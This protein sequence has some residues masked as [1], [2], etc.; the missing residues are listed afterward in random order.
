MCGEACA[1]AHTS[2]NACPVPHAPLLTNDP[3]PTPPLAGHAAAQQLRAH[4]QHGGPV[5]PPH[6]RRPPGRRLLLRHKVRCACHHRGAA[7]GGTRGQGAAQGVGHLAGWVCRV[8]SMP[9][10][11]CAAVCLAS[12]CGTTC[13]TCGCH[14]HCRSHA[15]LLSMWLL[16]ASC[17]C[18]QLPALHCTPFRCP[19]SGV[20][21]PA[22]IV[23]CCTQLPSFSLPPH[24]LPHTASVLLLPAGIVET[25]FF[26]VRAFGDP[27]AAK[28]AT[29]QFK[30][31]EPTDIADAIVWCLSAPAHMEVDDV[32]VRPTE[33]MI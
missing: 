1:A 8:W 10:C 13:W 20:L 24:A 19:A 27:E 21:L 15:V 18:T 32:V 28:R 11:C 33:Q 29:S 6:P 2:H 5:G 25:E 4:H 22:G 16:V 26:S 30:C 31:L 17:G 3:F 23:T 9:W 14:G 12:S 7:P